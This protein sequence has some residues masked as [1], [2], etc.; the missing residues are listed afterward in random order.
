MD[1]QQKP[2]AAQWELEDTATLTLR[3]ARGDDE[4]P[5]SDGKAVTLEIY[6]PG[7]VPGRKAKFKANRARDLRS[8]RAMRGEY[9]PNDQEN[10][11][12]ERAEKLTAF[13]QAVSPNSPFTIAQIFSNPRLFYI[14]D[15]VEEFISQPGN[16]TKA[17]SGI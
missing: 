5:G 8:F 13:T 15:Q 1:E 6:S 9:P 17:P 14:H 12:R 16:F 10:S 4:L 3:N 2:D 11:E 7:S